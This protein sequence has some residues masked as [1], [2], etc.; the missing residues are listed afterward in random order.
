LVKV[1]TLSNGFLIRFRDVS[2]VLR[3]RF[4]KRTRFSYSLI[5]SYLLGGGIL[6][7]EFPGYI[8]AELRDV[9]S[10]T[11]LSKLEF[12]SLVEAPNVRCVDHECQE[13]LKNSWL[14]GLR[15]SPRMIDHIQDEHSPT[16]HLGWNVA[17][18][19]PYGVG[20]G[21]GSVCSVSV[22]SCKKSHC[23]INSRINE[24]WQC[25]PI[26]CRLQWP[27][28]KLS[29]PTILDSVR[30]ELGYLPRR[31]YGLGFTPE[32]DV[33]RALEFKYSSA[34]W[35]YGIS[36]IAPREFFVPI[37]TQGVR[38]ESRGCVS[39]RFETAEETIRRVLG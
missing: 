4:V 15:L 10:D 27:V 21:R 26:A 18:P 11:L 31:S 23:R 20:Y 2:S 1:K 33:R 12:S 37:P 7:P 3:K 5:Y 9:V 32:Q 35:E 13:V 22:S 24:S 25:R 29:V 14:N 34:L 36:L 6:L 39:D 17:C 8:P 16:F 19:P 38:G 28:P 30:L